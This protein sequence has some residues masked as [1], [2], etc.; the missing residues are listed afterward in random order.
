MSKP[1][2][3]PKE[4]KEPK[5]PKDPKDY[6]GES[7]NARQSG[8]ESG[9]ST[10]KK[11]PVIMHLMV[12][13]SDR[14]LEDNI[15]SNIL[16]PIEDSMMHMHLDPYYNDEAFNKFSYTTISDTVSP[17]SCHNNGTSLAAMNTSV[18]MSNEHGHHHTMG[19]GDDGHPS[20]IQHINHSSMSGVVRL[21]ADFG[22]KS[23]NSEWPMSTSVYCHWCCHPFQGVPIGLPIKMTMNEQQYCVTGCFCSLECACAHNFASRESVDERLSRYSLLNG[24]AV[25]IGCIAQTPIRPAPDRL[26]LNIFGGHLSIDEFRVYA[27][28]SDRYIITNTSPMISVT[29]Q[30]EELNEQDT[31]SEYRYVPLD[32]ERVCRF[33][34]KIKL[35]RNKPLLNTKN[36]LDQSMK[37]KIT[38][39]SKQ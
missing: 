13:P 5:D 24:L 16:A 8:S 1:F 37:L 17:P 25:R 26:A 4:P 36:T 14:K 18:T 21:L 3:T 2:Y 12:P 9:P 27:S 28:S 20:S 7:S 15:G 34:E 10:A 35:K 6:G 30:L 23:R 38:L 31:H 39:P 33:Q 11:E 22:E 32:S 19:I 29:Q